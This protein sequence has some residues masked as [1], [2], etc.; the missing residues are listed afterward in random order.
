MGEASRTNF[1]RVY[2]VC[3]C[4]DH[5][6]TREQAVLHVYG[7]CDIPVSAVSQDAGFRGV[8]FG[9]YSL[10]AEIASEHHVK[11]FVC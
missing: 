5:F 10:G 7:D 11:S 2:S 9:Y 8:D 6:G 1:V 3:A 4:G